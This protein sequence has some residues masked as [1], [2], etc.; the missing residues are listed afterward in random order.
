[1]TEYFEFMASHPEL[2]INQDDKSSI[3]ILKDPEDIKRVEKTTN[4]KVGIMYK[5]N[6][7][8]L[9]K[10]AVVLPDHSD[11][12]YIRIIPANGKSGSVILPI[13]NDK[14]LLIN[15]YRHALRRFSWELPRGFAESHLSVIENAK[16]ELYEEC[17]LKAKKCEIL[18]RITTDSG[19]LGSEP[20]I[21]KALIEEKEAAV[22]SSNDSTEAIKDFKLVSIGELSN[23]ISQGLITD[24]F[25]ISAVFLAKAKNLLA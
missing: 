2:F 23:M 10:D 16:K 21:V 25:T 13:V 15:H 6:Y 8:I 11:G 4:Q 5:D 18:G 20:W 3:T 12:M 1:M 24:S 7:I 14:I 9:L 22:I 17:G 19:L